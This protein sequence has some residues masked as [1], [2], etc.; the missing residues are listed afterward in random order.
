MDKNAETKVSVIIPVYNCAIYLERCVESLL[1]QTLQ[2]IQF[3]FIDDCSTDDSYDKLVELI[4]RFPHLKDR[5]NLYKLDKNSGSAYV[6][7]Y[8]MSL[9]TSE[10]IGFVDADDWVDSEMFEQLYQKAKKENAQ[11]VWCDYINVFKNRQI[12]IS[13]TH[14]EDSETCIHAM[15]SGHMLGGMCNKLIKRDLFEATQ[16]S[17]PNGLN[18]CEDLRVNIQLFYYADKISYLNKGFYYYVK[19]KTDSI[20]AK[21]AKI[22][23]VNYEWLENVKAIVSF[24][25]KNLKIDKLQIDKFKLS[26]KKNLLVKGKSIES[27]QLW[28]S[29]FPESNYAIR[30]TDYP[31]VYKLLAFIVVKEWWDIARFWIF[32][33]YKLLKR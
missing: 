5:V 22:D 32:F 21:S 24:L 33:K 27:F 14:N 1:N 30:Y 3:F 16:V 18:M 12:Y 15:M 11:I 6:R 2:E 10:F 7:N 26:P 23:V 13:Q 8:G 19:Y 20:S 28:K 31:L 25:N 4:D 29:I 9:S 17:F